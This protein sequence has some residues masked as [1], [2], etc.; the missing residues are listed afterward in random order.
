MAKWNTT[1]LSDLGV[2]IRSIKKGLD[3]IQE[4]IDNRDPLFYYERELYYLAF[5]C[6]ITLMDAVEKKELPMDAVVKIP[7]RFL[8]IKKQT[9]RECWAQTVERFYS[10]S[11]SSQVVRGR[12]EDILT[13]GPSFHTYYGG[14]RNTLSKM[15]EKD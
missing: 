4:H 10:L 1:K 11:L 6:R 15:Q 5:L 12:M 9:V 7:I 8:R 3:R 14:F 13:E 2:R